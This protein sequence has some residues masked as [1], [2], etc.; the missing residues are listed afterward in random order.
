MKRDVLKAV[1]ALTMVLIFA[2]TASAQSEKLI[3]H[4][5]FDFQI[6][7]IPLSSGTYTIQLISGSVLAVVSTDGRSGTFN[8]TLPNAV[9]GYPTTDRLVFNRYGDRYFLSNVVWAGYDTG[10]K[11]RPSGAELELAREFRS[12]RILDTANK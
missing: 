10:R 2:A 1:F 8:M 12:V 4:I 9:K 3:V 5:P 11:L 6:G 7:K